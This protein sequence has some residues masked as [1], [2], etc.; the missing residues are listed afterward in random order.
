MKNYL[1][2]IIVILFAGAFYLGAFLLKGILSEIL[3]YIMGMG[4]TLG[5]ICYLIYHHWGKRK[6]KYGQEVKT[7][8][9]HSK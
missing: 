9:H 4:I 5:L 8:L 6:Q 1:K 3:V 2:T 7:K